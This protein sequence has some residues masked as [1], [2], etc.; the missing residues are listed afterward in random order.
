[1]C[2]PTAQLHCRLLLAFVA[3]SAVIALAWPAELHAAERWT[4]PVVGDVITP[5]RN[6]ADPYARG[7]HRGIDVAAS[8]GSPVAAAA[9]GTVRFAGTAGSSGLT[10]SIRTA[11]GLL[12]T[13]YLHLSSVKVGEGDRVRLGQ[14][15][16]AVGTSGRRSASAPHLHFGV[17]EAGRRHAYRNPLDLLPPPGTP[18]VRDRPR[19][20]VPA[21]VPVRVGPSPQPVR[22]RSPRR[23]RVPRRGR[24]PAGRRVPLPGG[25]RIPVP[26]GRPGPVPRGHPLPR[27][28]PLPSA[29]RA[30]GRAPNPHAAPSRGPAPEPV[31]DADRLPA[32]HRVRETSTAE[33]PKPAASPDGG[34]DFGWALA[35][36]GLLLAAACLGRPGSSDERGASRGAKLGA[37]VRPLLGRR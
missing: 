33:R 7:Q 30:P 25:R 3:C 35:C 23:T 27:L 14:Q 5:Y 36:L 17:R 10:V 2:T 29:R 19:V 4:W 11:D 31:P 6:G 1:M 26:G 18:P 34:P 20:P 22:A 13:S 15:V 12:D 16:G 8:N 32:P 37:I 24:V 21:G 9:A 28:A